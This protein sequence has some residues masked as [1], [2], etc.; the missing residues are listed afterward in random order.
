MIQEVLDARKQDFAKWLTPAVQKVLTGVKAMCLDYHKAARIPLVVNTAGESYTNGKS[1]TVSLP[2]YF[3]DPKYNETFW[4]LVMKASTAHECQHIN[5]SSLGKAAEMAKN[6]AK[7]MRK[8]YGL[9][10]Q[11]GENLAFQM[12]NIIEDGRIESIIVSRMPGLLINFKIKNGE[13]RAHGT[14]QK[15][16]EPGDSQTEY[17]HFMNQI[18]SY[19]KCGGNLPGIRKY[20]GER[21]EQEFMAIKPYIKQGVMSYSC[22]ECLRNV[23]KLLMTAAPY[24]NDLLKAD[25]DF[26][27]QMEKM[28]S[29]P[30]F[31]GPAE[32]TEFNESGK[33]GQNLL[34]VFQQK[35]EPGTSEKEDTKQEDSDSASGKSENNQDETSSNRQQSEAGK[36][37]NQQG[38]S[39][40]N[41]EAIN[42]DSQENGQNG[43][44]SGEDT[45]NADNNEN[46]SS[47]D[48]DASNKGNGQEDAQSESDS[49]DSDNTDA[50]SSNPPA[51]IQA[52]QKK[53]QA[54]TEQ[55]LSNEV[56]AGT[57]MS[58][59]FSNVELEI[60]GYT[61]DELKQ[62]RAVIEQELQR[63][64]SGEIKADEKYSWRG[65]KFQSQMKAL[66]Q[67]AP[68]KEV[69]VPCGSAQTPAE[70]MI[71]AKKLK[72]E[73]IKI[74]KVKYQD[75]RNVRHGQIDARALWKLRCREDNFFEQRNKRNKSSVAIY[76]LIDN[77]GSMQSAQKSIAARYAA[78]IMEEAFA[79]FASCKIAMFASGADVT[80]WIIKEFDKKERFNASFNSLNCVT[81]TGGN[82]DGYSIRI[83]VEELR[84][85]PERKKFL[86]VLSDG[87]P[88]DYPSADAGQ[89]DVRQAVH[90]ARKQ[91]I[92][93]I[94]IM[95]GSKAFQSASL[96]AF[97]R[98]YEKNIITSSVEHITEDLAKLFK[99]LVV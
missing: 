33:S 96:P 87:L 12:F 80:H 59:D 37:G 38:K 7:Y 65:Q 57:D 91:Q 21:L 4:L 95:F 19:A 51:K 49:K 61:E 55:N 9:H 67:N 35:P 93:V 3:L 77:S 83:A 56:P 73:L 66:Y 30:D 5:S 17:T 11:I 27:K 70:I 85:R 47:S 8:T 23:E 99:R 94:P 62:A 52:G 90:M 68:Y 25:S 46:N 32:E 72:Q 24:L 76:L 45:D 42:D 2:E 82:K 20:H 18:L 29:T 81:P 26:L 60:R 88:S 39:S 58:G 97:Q 89:E 40:A 13:I 43:A 28:V 10:E 44:S 1:I 79:E 78:A 98:M 15:K 34:W 53:M 86:I 54:D 48:E 14:I 69:S 41:E 84:K 6:Y 64:E 75:R 74:L 22:G 16:A 92:E 63:W 31:T 50:S 71:P 36:Q